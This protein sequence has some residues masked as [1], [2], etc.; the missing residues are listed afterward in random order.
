MTKTKAEEWLFDPQDW[1]DNKSRADAIMGLIQR[2]IREETAELQEDKR[3][4]SRRSKISA[5]GTII[6]SVVAVLSLAIAMGWI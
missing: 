2:E 3:R 6:S 1:M 5:A 4:M